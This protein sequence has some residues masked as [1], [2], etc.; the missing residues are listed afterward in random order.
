MISSVLPK[1]GTWSC[2]S[3]VTYG[4]QKLSTLLGK[5]DRGMIVYTASIFEMRRCPRHF[6]PSECSMHDC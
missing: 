4:L 3:S 2:Q 5:V 1:S 6:L